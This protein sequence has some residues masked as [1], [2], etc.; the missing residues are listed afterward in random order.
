M[1]STHSAFFSIHLTMNR[2]AAS[3]NRRYLFVLPFCAAVAH[4]TLPVPKTRT[5]KSSVD[6]S[7]AR[8]RFVP[9]LR[10]SAW[11]RAI[12]HR[13]SSRHP[14]GQ[15]PLVLGHRDSRKEKPRCF[16]M[17]V[18]MLFTSFLLIGVLAHE[19]VVWSVRCRRWK[20]VTRGR[21]CCCAFRSLV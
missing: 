8:R 6:P 1:A 14:T 13:A 10:L 17:F 20:P 9:G 16:R 3:R 2:L 7:V 15:S 18:S 12:P 11:S 4:R 5:W 19:R 21:T